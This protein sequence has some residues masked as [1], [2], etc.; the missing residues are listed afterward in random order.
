MTT[1]LYRIRSNSS[2]FWWTESLLCNPN[3]NTD[4]YVIKATV[5]SVGPLHRLDH[6]MFQFAKAEKMVAGLTVHHV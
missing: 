3:S 4:A 6:G 1:Q 5:I 2:G